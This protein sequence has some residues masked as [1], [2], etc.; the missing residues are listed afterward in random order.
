MLLKR[1]EEGEM[2]SPSFFAGNIGWTDSGNMFGR[3][4]MEKKIV[5]RENMA[6]YMQQLRNWTEEVKDTGL[7]EMAAFFRARL[8]GY[9][10]HMSLWSRAYKYLSLIHI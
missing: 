5:I 6:E 8:D 1:C 2:I 10:E 4:F 9:E 3:L 7:E